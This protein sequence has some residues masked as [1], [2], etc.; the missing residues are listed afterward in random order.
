[1]NPYREVELSSLSFLGDD[2]VQVRHTLQEYAEE[3]LILSYNGMIADAQILSDFCEYIT[4]LDKKKQ[5]DSQR[6]GIEKAL[7]RKSQGLGHYGRPLT[8][9]PN[10][11]DKRI[12]QCI[13]NG[14]SLK[15]YCTE[16][17]MRPSTFY[18][19]A[20]RSKDDLIL[21]RIGNRKK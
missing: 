20:R 11:F 12:E 9:L 15:S 19:Y 16:L 10:D 4:A 18:K 7:Q 21:S 6:A 14:K 1:M 5:K 13:L 3:K 17:Q 8:Q 2:L